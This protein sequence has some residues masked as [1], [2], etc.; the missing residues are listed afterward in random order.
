MS[1]RRTEASK[2]LERNVKKHLRFWGGPFDSRADIAK[3]MGID[4]SALSRAL[5][6]NPTLE[7]IEKIAFALG[8]PIADLFRDNKKLSEHKGVEGYLIVDD[9]IEHIKSKE[10]VLRLK[11]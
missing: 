7:T 6:G 11:L 1:K 10:D 3:A 9:R 5:N 8:V 4:P 2:L